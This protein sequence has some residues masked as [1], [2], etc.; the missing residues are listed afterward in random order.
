MAAPET[1]PTA[2]PVAGQYLDFLLKDGK[3][4]S[5]SIATKPA[6]E[7][8]LEIETFVVTV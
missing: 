2:C 1:Q 4:R 7:G 8:V 3:R 6:P 5:Y